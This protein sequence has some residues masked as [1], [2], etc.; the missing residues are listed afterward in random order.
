MGGEGDAWQGERGDEGT[1]GG[2]DG[3]RDEGTG[4]GRDGIQ[5]QKV[6]GAIQFSETSENRSARGPSGRWFTV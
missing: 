6:T 1:G 5:K 3:R 4:G 2:R